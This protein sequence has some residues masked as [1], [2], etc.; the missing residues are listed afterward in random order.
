MEPKWLGMSFRDCGAFSDK[1]FKRT[2]K[3]FNTIIACCLVNIYPPKH[4]VKA[5]R[6]LDDLLEQDP[7][8]IDCRLARGYLH[9]HAKRWP[10]AK[11]DFNSVTTSLEHD[12]S[13]WLEAEEESAWCQVQ[14]G[15]VESGTEAL[16]HVL[17]ILETADGQEI[18][19]ARAW[20]RL[21]KA[22]W[23]ENDPNSFLEAYKLWITS[24]K[25]STSFAPAYTSLG[26]Y[27]SDYAQ[28][29]DTVR[30]SRCF[31]KAF[32]LDFKEVEAARRLAEGFT[33]EDEWDLAE[34]VAKRVIEGEGAL[35]SGQ[36]S[37]TINPRHVATNIWAWKVVGLAALV[38]HLLEKDQ[39]N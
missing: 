11:E 6:L 32:E 13:R 30:A 4:H 29:P 21:G 14:M 10:L 33:E 35:D 15:E 8:Q 12:N 24:L 2:S 26:V 37:V 25:R 9:Q 38:R 3:A 7:S 5:L 19:Q 23:N 28:P 27:Y 17:E 1:I 39:D 34:I 22:I 16:R 36:K 20:W 18:A 31:Q